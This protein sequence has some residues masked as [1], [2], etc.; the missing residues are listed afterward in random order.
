MLNYFISKTISCCH[1]ITHGHHIPRILA[2]YNK[3]RNLFFRL[4][5]TVPKYLNYSFWDNFTS[6]I[7][8]LHKDAFHNICIEDK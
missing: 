6:G 2:F 8:G 7:L 3:T 1:I 4:A 5:N